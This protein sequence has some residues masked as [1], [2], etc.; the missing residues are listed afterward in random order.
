MSSLIG[1]PIPDLEL[2]VLDPYRQPGS[3]GCGWRVVC[4]RGGCSE[5]LSESSRT[6]GGAVY[7]QSVRGAGERLYKTGDLGRYLADGDIEYLDR[8][9][10]QVKMRGYR[11]ELGEIESVLSQHRLVSEAVVLAREEG[12]GDKHLMAYV[13]F[14]LG[15]MCT[16]SE[17]RSFL[18]GKLPDYM[19]PS[20]F[21]VLD[22]LPLRPTVR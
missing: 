15:Q 14:N 1:V 11:I 17:L 19:V 13:V 4:W 2:Y 18:K 12:P 7:R 3:G 21:V 6:D 5:R 20:A 8:I 10:N 22:S 16:A 9:D